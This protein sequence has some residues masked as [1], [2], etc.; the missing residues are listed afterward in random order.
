MRVLILG[1]SGIMG[2]HMRLCVPYGIEPQYCR[3][4]ADDLH[5]GCDLTSADSRRALLDTNRPEVIVNLAG[6]NNTDTVE[7]DPTAARGINVDAPGAIA[8]WCAQ[9]GG[10]YIHVSSQGV[11]SGE[12]PPYSPQSPCK[13]LN[14]YGLQKLEAEGIVSQSAANWTIVRP[15]FVLGVRPLPHLCR[16]NPVESILS[17]GQPR[18][19]ADRW[20]SPLF[21]RD[22]AELLWDLVERRPSRQ[23]VHLGNPARISR[24]DLACQLGVTAEPVPHDSFPGLAPR[25]L[26]TTY[27]GSHWRSTLPEGVQKCREDWAGKSSPDQAERAREIGLFLGL[28]EDECFARLAQGFHPAHAAVAADFR[29]ANP[30]D[31]ERLL[32]WYRK[33]EAYIWELSAYH[34]DAGF[35]YA[36]LCE[37][38]AERLRAGGARRVLCLGDGIGDLSLSL[39]RRGLEAAYHDLAGSRTAAFADFRFRKN[40]DA[41]P[42]A[43]HETQGW[44][45][46]PLL[47]AGRFDAVVS[48]DFLE[49]VTDVAA[50][51]RVIR[52]ILAHGGFFMAQ[53]AFAIG[54]G[55][56]GSI[57][58]HLERNDRYE[59]EW[60]PLMTSLGMQQ[61]SSNW[62]RKPA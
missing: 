40:L 23:I 22:A 61:E 21:A 43:R 35:N 53:N 4:Y 42:P 6:Q 13:P 55:R 12:A 45:P 14:Q 19:V 15:T 44:D 54:S 58:C 3:A 37:G 48:L 30:Q 38:V 59:K 11:F 29:T 27:C 39:R 46:S 34:C 33:T 26:D 18:Q 28:R 36:G 24:Y 32:D 52:D 62:W 51:S 9:S 60:T 16:R 1:A 25:P 56:D 41:N 20:F 8:S 31:D 10:H 47:A 57:P 49:H 2:Q 5:L 50:W 7:A 17:G